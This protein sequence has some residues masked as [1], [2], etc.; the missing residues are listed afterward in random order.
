MLNIYSFTGYV[1]FDKSLLNTFGRH[2]SFKAICKISLYEFRV[3]VSH[4]KN[5]NRD[6][7][8][9]FKFRK[10]GNNFFELTFILQ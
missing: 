5:Q 4:V 9:V 2:L 8:L 3:L 6:M 7:F 10:V 1:I